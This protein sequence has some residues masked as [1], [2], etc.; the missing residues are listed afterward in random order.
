[1]ILGDDLGSELYLT[2]L[3]RL[4]FCD[5]PVLKNYSIKPFVFAE[6]IYYPPANAKGKEY[7]RGGVGFGVSIPLPVN[8]MLSL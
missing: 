2:V 1:V 6:G 8:D 3:G 4:E 5:V 7:C